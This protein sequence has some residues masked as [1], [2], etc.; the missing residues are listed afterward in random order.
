MSRDPKDVVT[1]FVAALNARDW[2]AM[3][4]LF[5]DDLTYTVMGFDLPGA[6]SLDKATA[7]AVLPGMMSVFAEG[8]P[9]LSIVRM[10]SEGTWVNLEAEGS[11]VFVDGTPY[12]NRYSNNFEVVDGQIRTLR[13]YMDT[14]HMA[15]LLETVSSNLGQPNGIA[16]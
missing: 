3:S 14:Q 11:G 16:Q 1:A 9:R 7:L 6:G 13:E 12:E 2:S 15:A 5:H 8:S 4:E 10:I